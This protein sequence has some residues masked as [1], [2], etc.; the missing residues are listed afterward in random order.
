[1]NLAEHVVG[2]SGRYV[3][4]RVIPPTDDVIY[5][6]HSFFLIQGQCNTN[7]SQISLLSYEVQ[8]IKH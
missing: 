4:L 5:F 3:F 8:G 1:V 2:S 7:M 6:G